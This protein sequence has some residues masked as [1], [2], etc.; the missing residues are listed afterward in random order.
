ML[1]FWHTLESLIFANYQCHPLRFMLHDNN[2][3]DWTSAM[4][5]LI[6]LVAFLG[7]DSNEVVQRFID[8]TFY[9]CR[10]NRTD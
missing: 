8:S 1:G 2:S 4:C 9:R 3:G 6:L 5:S 7:I 10:H